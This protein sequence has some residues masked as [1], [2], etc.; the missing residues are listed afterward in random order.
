MQ[1]DCANYRKYYY[2]KLN[3]ST[4]MDQSVNDN[5]IQVNYY[6]PDV[7]RSGIVSNPPF[8]FVEKRLTIDPTDVIREMATLPTFYSQIETIRRKFVGEE[9]LL[10][11][12]HHDPAPVTYFEMGTFPRNDMYW[13]RETL[14]D[15]RLYGQAAR[16]AFYNKL[17]SEVTFDAEIYGTA[18]P[19]NT[20]VLGRIANSYIEILDP[21][22]TSS[23]A[24]PL[25]P[26]YNASTKEL[27][28]SLTNGAISI[29]NVWDF[30]ENG[31][32]ANP[33]SAN[34]WYNPDDSLSTTVPMK[35]Y[36]YRGD[37]DVMDEG[38]NYFLIEFDFVVN[39]S[40]GNEE[41]PVSRSASQTWTMPANSSI[42]VKF[43]EGSTQITKI[44]TNDVEDNITFAD[45]S[46][47]NDL[48]SSTVSYTHLTLPTI[49]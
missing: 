3:V 16:D 20:S 17:K 40:Q 15:N 24:L 45:G 10:F 42:S 47:A 19:T 21:Y 48:D 18:A 12:Y 23:I 43:F 37:D 30:I 35:L 36:L 5:S 32:N 41:N 1:F 8:D 29:D 9:Y 7:I 22:N 34:L 44:I 25:Y 46:N 4:I 28:Y 33:I 49:E 2:P 14:G 39:S 26:T 13:D 38:E 31:T 6:I 11:E 27:K